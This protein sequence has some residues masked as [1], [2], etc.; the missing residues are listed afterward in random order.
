[1]PKKDYKDSPLKLVGGLWKNEAKESGKTYLT[2][3]LEDHEDPDRK[4]D[5][6][7]FKNEKKKQ[8]NSPDFFV[9]FDTTKKNFKKKA[10]DD[11][12]EETD[13]DDF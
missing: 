5:L 12:E 6:V 2:M 3:K 11:E 9:Y 7:A 4:F 10:K 1:M 8:E 13:E